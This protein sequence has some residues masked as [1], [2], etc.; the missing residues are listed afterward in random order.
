[1]HLETLASTAEALAERVVDELRARG[2][3][4]P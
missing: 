3:L 4:E 2:R 1:M